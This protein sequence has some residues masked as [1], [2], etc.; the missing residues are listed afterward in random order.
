MYKAA[1]LFVQPSR[2]EGASLALMEAICSG[3]PV[4]ATQTGHAHQLVGNKNGRLVEVEN[5]SQ[6]AEAIDGAVQNPNWPG[7]ITARKQVVGEYGRQ[8]MMERLT[9]VYNLATAHE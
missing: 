4:V 1:D 8:A 6:L 5:P 2:S 7:L 9:E 3:L